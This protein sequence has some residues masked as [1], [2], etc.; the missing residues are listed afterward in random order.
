MPRVLDKTVMLRDAYFSKG[1]SRFPMERG[2]QKWKLKQG[3]HIFWD[4]N[5]PV[6]S[7]I[8]ICHN[9]MPIGGMP[10]W[11]RYHGPNC[12]M[13]PLQMEFTQDQ[14]NCWYLGLL[15]WTLRPLLQLQRAAAPAW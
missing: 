1:M 9:S 12:H 4:Y 6:T 8:N 13:F 3:F 2:C 10:A 5:F 7:T 14:P 15:D 11:R